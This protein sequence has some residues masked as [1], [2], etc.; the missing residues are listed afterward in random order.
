MHT[1]IAVLC[2]Y[3]ISVTNGYFV[4]TGSRGIL[5]NI[6]GDGKPGTVD[7]AGINWTAP[8]V[9]NDGCEREYP[10]SPKNSQMLALAGHRYGLVP[11]ITPYSPPYYLTVCTQNRI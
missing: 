7:Y 1:K 5:S 8:T 2:I 3:V 6:F 11:Q 4:G 10:L 9:F